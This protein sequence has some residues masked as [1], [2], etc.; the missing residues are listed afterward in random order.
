MA[1]VLV[2]AA[3]HLPP[4]LS[5][6]GNQQIERHL[7]PRVDRVWADRRVQREHA[8]RLAMA[9]WTLEGEVAP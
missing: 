2:A 4:F 5:H 1:R 8:T 6:L 7:A 3:W 9:A